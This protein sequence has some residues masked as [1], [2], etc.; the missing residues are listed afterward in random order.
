MRQSV[1]QSRKAVELSNLLH[2][3]LSLYALASFG[4]LAPSQIA[5]AQIVYTPAH[6]MLNH[7]GVISIDLNHN[8]TADLLIRQGPWFTKGQSLAAVPSPGGG[9]Q[10]GGYGWAAAMSLGSEIGPSNRNPFSPRKDAMFLLSK[11]GYYYASWAPNTIGHYLRIKFTINGETH[12]GWAR[13]TAQEHLQTRQ[14]YCT[15]TGYAYETQANTPIKAG[16]TGG[17][18]ADDAEAGLTSEVFSEPRLGA[19][20]AMLGV[21]ALGASGLPAWRRMEVPEQAR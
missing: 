12:Y 1:R 4:L 21:L 16:D 19:K 14:I 13:V 7:D 15:L 11:F 8:G 6:A 17:G 9:I 3:D 2:H 5:E 18:S 10:E 20:A